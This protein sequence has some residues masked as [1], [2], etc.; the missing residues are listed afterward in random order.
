MYCRKFLMVISVR[1]TKKFLTKF[2]VSNFHESMIIYNTIEN[3]VFPNERLTSN[4]ENYLIRKFNKGKLSL[5]NS[6]TTCD[7]YGKGDGKYYREYA[8]LYIVFFMLVNIFYLINE[9]WKLLGSWPTLQK[10]DIYGKGGPS[11]DSI[12][13]FP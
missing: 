1:I 5:S 10:K 9:N 11:H 2:W 13:F 3:W 7:I 4:L 8:S 12:C 6:Q